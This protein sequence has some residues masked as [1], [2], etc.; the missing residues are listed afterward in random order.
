MILN[1]KHKIIF[2]ILIAL[3]PL[4]LGIHLFS[5]EINIEFKHFWN[6]IFQFNDTN[7]SEV[8]VREFRIPRMVIAVIAGGGLSIAGLFM[9]T[10][11]NNPLAGPY[12]LGIN[13]GSSLFVAF[14][15]MSGIPFLTSNLGTISSSLLGAFI[16][17]MIILSFSYLVKSHIS[18]L[19]IGI[20]LGGFASAIV[21]I[22]QSLSDPQELKQF[23]M[24][25]MGSLQQVEFEDLSIIL[26]F[27]MIGA[28]SSLFVIK[29]LNALVL[30]E[31]Q[32]L[33]LGIHVKYVRLALIII[34][35]ILT[36]VIT[37]FCGPIAF[38]GLAVPNLVKMIF[39]TQSHGILMLGCFFI[40]SLFLISC[41]IIIQLVES[42]IHIPI[43][44]LTSIIGAPF[45]IAIVLKRLA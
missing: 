27:S 8:I 23:T 26:F 43:N 36:G 29:P 32:A 44:A 11:F 38:V 1:R 15:V 25:S 33:T 12:I 41:D 9:Q 34:T 16:F 39:K 28:I 2:L 21:S 35:A 20:M 37:A 7:T 3:L 5:G 22:L 42:S 6:A 13:S 17:G 19:L 40:G 31:S 30:G 10:M 45:V 24:W 4:L 14:S 18:L